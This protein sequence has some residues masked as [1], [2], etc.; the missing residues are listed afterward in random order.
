M[1]PLFAFVVMLFNELGLQYV[2]LEEQTVL[3]LTYGGENGRWNCFAQ[4]QEPAQRFVF[5][6]VLIP[7]VP[8]ARRLAVAEYITRANYDL[9]LGNFEL[10]LEDGEVRF[11]TSADLS[12]MTPT[13]A[14]LKTLIFANL[15]ATDRYFPGLMSVLFAD[16]L[17]AQAIALME[18]A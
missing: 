12:G 2:K 3:H 4:V 8:A 15:L 9:M 17:P 11:K 18:R 16:A 7:R 5:Y 1:G 10:D 6:S 13:T 14:F